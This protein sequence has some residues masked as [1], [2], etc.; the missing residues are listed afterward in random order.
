MKKEEGYVSY[1]D[2]EP[3][4][5]DFDICSKKVKDSEVIRYVTYKWDEEK[6]EYVQVCNNE[7]PHRRR[8]KFPQQNSKK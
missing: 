3:Y 4:Q 2:Y 7:F 8:R 5:Y 1:E 6:G